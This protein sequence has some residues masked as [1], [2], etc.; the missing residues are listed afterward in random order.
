V[1][2]MANNELDEQAHGRGPT[3]EKHPRTAPPPKKTGRA[4]DTTP[5]WHLCVLLRQS[6]IRSP[7][8]LQLQPG[9]VSP[10]CTATRAFTFSPGKR[11]RL[12]PAAGRWRATSLWNPRSA[13]SHLHLLLR[14]PQ[15]MSC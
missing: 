2:I 12:T 9:S 15:R 11:L 3:G 14:T 8:N 13:L 7:L 1:I 4:T 6:A 10:S 5:Q